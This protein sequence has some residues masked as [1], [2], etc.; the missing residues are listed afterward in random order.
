MNEITQQENQ[1]KRY[2]PE[3]TQQVKQAAISKALTVQVDALQRNP[4]RTSLSDYNKCVEIA[5][6]YV[7]ACANVGVLPSVEGLCA[8]L[9]V[10]RRWFYSFIERHPDSETAQYFDRLR[11]SWAATRMAL[12]ERGILEPGG[13]HPNYPRPC[14]TAWFLGGQRDRPS[15]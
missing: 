11:L 6:Q 10:S 7:T 8:N 3:M 14:Q 4:E 9:G 12:V 15:E 5:S 1:Q 2:T 13:A